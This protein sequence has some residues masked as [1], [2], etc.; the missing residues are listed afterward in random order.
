V[1][2]VFPMHLMMVLTV[3]LFASVSVAG[4]EQ[5]EAQTAVVQEEL[6]VKSAPAAHPTVDTIPYKSSDLDF[7]DTISNSLLYLGILFA[8][9]AAAVFLFKR[10]MVSTGALPDKLGSHIRLV[11]RKTLSTKTT[12]HLLDIDGREVL[13]A[14]SPHGQSIIELNGSPVS[15]DRDETE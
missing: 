7:E 14:E 5:V 3:C 11:D 4:E 12:V 1:I 10:R 9:A 13:L 8:I 15:T 6:S 2:K